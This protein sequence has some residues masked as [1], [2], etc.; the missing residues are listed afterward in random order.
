MIRLEHGWADQGLGV[1]VLSIDEV[2]NKEHSG[3]GGSESRTEA[4]HE[5]RVRA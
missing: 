2:R 5:N 3:K 1:R 4:E